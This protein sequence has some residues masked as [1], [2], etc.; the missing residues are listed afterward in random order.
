M[1]F[2]RALMICLIPALIDGKFLS[3]LFS[4]QPTCIEDDAGNCCK[5]LSFVFIVSLDLNIHNILRSLQ[6]QF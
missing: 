5:F 6:N 2:A 3:R 1:T 4:P